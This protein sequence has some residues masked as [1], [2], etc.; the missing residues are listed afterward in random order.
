MHTNSVFV[1]FGES[2]L[3]YFWGDKRVSVAVATNPVR[4]AEF[5]IGILLA[6]VFDIP[7]G[8]LP[9]EF[10][11][12][13]E[14]DYDLGKG[15]TQIRKSISKFF[16][17]CRTLHKNFSSIPKS[18]ELGA[19]GIGDAATVMRIVLCGLITTE[20]LINGFMANANGGSFC[21]GWMGS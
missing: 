6:E 17:N 7:A 1:K 20:L 5:W 14:A 10:E 18:L 9:S 4:E 16:L 11:R 19:E 3:G 2:A 12:T 21:L 8:I 15:F 13:V